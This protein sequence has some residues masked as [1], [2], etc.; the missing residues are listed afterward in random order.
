M[1]LLESE[2]TKEHCINVVDMNTTLQ[3]YQDFL[4]YKCSFQLTNEE[5]PPYA[6]VSKDNISIHLA[7]TQDPNLSGIG[8]CYIEVDNIDELYNELNKVGAIFVR[9]IENSDYGIRD[10]VIKDYEGNKLSF[11]QNI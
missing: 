4:A 1:S 11:G 10:F 8:F 7:L 6:I 9:N 3:W 5:T 2:L